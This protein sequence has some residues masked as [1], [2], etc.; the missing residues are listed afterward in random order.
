[1][2]LLLALIGLGL[3]IAGLVGVWHG[4]WRLMWGAQA[5]MTLFVVGCLT[6]DHW[7]QL[8]GI[9][10][11]DGFVLIGIIMIGLVA[12]GISIGALAVASII[13]SIRG[14]QTAAVQAQGKSG[15]A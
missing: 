8:A 7:Y 13:H 1:M 2:G 4:N 10:R 5:Y 9:N 11:G 3:L 12:A 15:A 6:I 14:G